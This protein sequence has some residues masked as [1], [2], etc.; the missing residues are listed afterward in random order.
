RLSE[1]QDDRADDRRGRDSRPPGAARGAC[2]PSLRLGLHRRVRR[3]GCR[4]VGPRPVGAGPQGG[5]GDSCRDRDHPLRPALPRGAARA[6]ALPPGALSGPHGR[7][8]PPGRLCDGAGLRLRF[9]A[10]H[11]SGAG[12]RANARRQRGQPRRWSSPAPRLLAGARRAVRP[13]CRR[14]RAIHRVPAA[15]PP[16]SAARRNADGRAA[17]AHGRAHAD[18]IAQLVWAVAYRQR[19]VLGAHRGGRYARAA[20]NRDPQGGCK[21]TAAPGA[22]RLPIALTIAGSDS[23]GGAGIQADLKTFSA[24]GVYGASVLTA[25]TAQNT[26]GVAAVEPVAAA[27]VVAQMEAVLSDLQVGAIKTGMLANAAIVGAVA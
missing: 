9:D 13:G 17:G 5:V 23:S 4:R 19:A 27:F 3:T 16:A 26:Q 6:A 18:G 7:G 20:A 21:M 2:V 12:N 25:L 10:M 15:L 11:R 8:E 1:R 14:D 24:F 22:Q